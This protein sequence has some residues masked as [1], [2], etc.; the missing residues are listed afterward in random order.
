MFLADRAGGSQGEQQLHKGNKEESGVLL[1]PCQ[2]GS[3]EG[4]EG[5]DAK[6]IEGFVYAR[7]RESVHGIVLLM[8]SL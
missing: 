1:S 7:W 4:A 2:R 6:V 8:V 5:S 3:A